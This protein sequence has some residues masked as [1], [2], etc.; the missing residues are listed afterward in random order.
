M[1]PQDIKIKCPKCRNGVIESA[2]E[3]KGRVVTRFKQAQRRGNQ[4]VVQCRSCNAWIKIP[5]DLI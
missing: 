5:S 1:S 3:G 2:K 4:L